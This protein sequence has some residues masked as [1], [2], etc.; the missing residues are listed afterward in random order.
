MKWTDQLAEELLKA[1]LDDIRGISSKLPVTK[2][3]ITPRII[4]EFDFKSP[5]DMYLGSDYFERTK[6]NQ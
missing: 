6:E 5:N 3:N 1:V 4:P 2:T